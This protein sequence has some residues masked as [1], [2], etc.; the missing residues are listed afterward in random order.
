MTKLIDIKDSKQAEKIN[1]LA[2]EAPYDVWLSTDTVMLDARSLMS[3]LSLVGTR[4]AVVAE[5]ERDT[6]RRGI[7]NFGHTLGHA[8]ELAYHYE[9]YTHGEGVAAG[10]VKILELEEKKGRNVAALKARLIALL[11]KAVVRW[12]GEF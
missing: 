5:D 1:L 3:V 2:S 7:L 10:M 4:A 6:G 12:R 8:Y 11:E 9:T